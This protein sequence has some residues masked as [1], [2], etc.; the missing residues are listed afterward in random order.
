MD[1]SAWTECKVERVFGRTMVEAHE[2]RA[3]GVMERAFT[4]EKESS[5]A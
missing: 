4:C 2:R 5:Y 1:A 3:K